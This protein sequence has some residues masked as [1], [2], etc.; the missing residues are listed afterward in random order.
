MK[1]AP[2]QPADAGSLIGR[3]EEAASG[4]DLL[5]SGR[6]RLLTVTG[7]PGV[8]K[9]RL[10]AAIAQSLQDD[11]A[12]GI[13]RVG[14]E[15]LTDP[16]TFRVERDE[17]LAGGGAM[18]DK[19]T[20]ANRHLSGDETLAWFRTARAQT[21][22]AARRVEQRALALA[23]AAR[24]VLDLLSPSPRSPRLAGRSLRPEV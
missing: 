4:R 8:G 7:P 21:V 16:E 18:V 17:T 5:T 9:T 23:Q 6:V 10:A 11:F 22:A 13:A 14:L 1:L 12:D 15:S 20:E 3:D 24:H 19:I 2:C